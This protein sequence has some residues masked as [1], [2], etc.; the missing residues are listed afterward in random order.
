MTTSANSEVLS[1]WQS[2]PPEYAIPD[3]PPSEAEA[4]EYCRRLAR[5]HYENVAETAWEGTTWQP[6]NSRNGCAPDVGST[7]APPLR[8]AERPESRT[9]AEDSA[10]PT[11]PR[12]L[13]KLS[14]K[15]VITRKDTKDHEAN[16]YFPSCAL[17]SSVVNRR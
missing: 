9:P 14:C 17:V 15:T 5:S 10:S 6:R 4:Q 2:L 3:V 1:G 7:L 13:P 11:I 12:Y 8:L 16:G